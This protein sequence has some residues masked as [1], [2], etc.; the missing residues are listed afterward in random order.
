MMESQ[1]PEKFRREVMEG[2]IR[3]YEKQVQRHNEGICPLHRPK[4][5]EADERSRKKNVQRVA[6]YKP[7]DTVLFCPPTP[8]SKLAKQLKTIADDTYKNTHMRIKV[9]EKAGIKIK[10]LLPGLKEKE[11]CRRVECFIHKNGGKGKCKTENVVYEGK[12]MT[13]S[14]KGPTSKPD[15]QGQIKQIQR[16]PG[17]QSLYVGESSRSAY[18][19]GMQHIAAIEQPERH[20]TNA[21]AKHIIEC[22]KGDHEDVKFK[23]NVVKSFKR[24]LERQIYEGVAI[25][26]AKVDLLMNSKLDHYQP[27][28]G[29]VVITNDVRNE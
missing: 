15:K 24:P 17:T 16:T 3:G 21:F 5:Y 25:H 14:S 6:W 8:S 26:N 23:V 20:K 1:Y 29:R 28:V 27:A 12:C 7:Y 11:P 4:G 2:G 9:V 10:S 22:H 19:R 13:C 18:Q